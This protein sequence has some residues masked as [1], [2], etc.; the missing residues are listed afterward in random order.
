MQLQQGDLF[1]GMDKGFV[2]DA[3]ELSAK[4]AFAEGDYLFH[5]GDRATDFYILLTGRIKLILGKSEKV[6]YMARH[7]GEIIGWS[8]L[9]DRE[10]YSASGQCMEPASLLKR[11]YP[12]YRPVKQGGVAHRFPRFPAFP[13]LHTV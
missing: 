13:T 11:L 8:S 9:T 6:V 5:E 1:W 2:K 7:A 10:R 4:V 3:M 12:K